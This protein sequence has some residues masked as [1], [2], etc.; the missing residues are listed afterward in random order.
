MSAFARSTEWVWLS[1]E[2]E[3]KCRVVLLDPLSLPQAISTCEAG[4]ASRIP[5]TRKMTSRRFI[6]C[7][8]RG[9]GTPGMLRLHPLPPSLGLREDR[10]ACRL[11]DLVD[12]G[13]SPDGVCL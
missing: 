1:S 9:P 5:P 10:V 7:M 12:R 2:D 11:P 6:A 4:M 8:S 3:L 13:C